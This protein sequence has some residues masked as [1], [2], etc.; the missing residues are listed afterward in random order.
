MYVCIQIYREDETKILS[1]ENENHEFYI[2]S[3]SCSPN[4]LSYA[5][6]SML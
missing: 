2:N 5:S 4:L 1:Q 6:N 3:I